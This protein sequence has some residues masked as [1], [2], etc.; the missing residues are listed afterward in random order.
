MMNYYKQIHKEDF[1]AIVQNKR[2]FII[3]RKISQVTKPARILLIEL[4][5]GVETGRTFDLKIRHIINDTKETGL[6]S[7]FQILLFE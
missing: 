1:E 7:G 6:K 2:N 3:V 5:K 4:E